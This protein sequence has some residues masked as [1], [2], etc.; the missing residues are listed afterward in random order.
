MNRAR[1]STNYPLSL[2]SADS[3][4]W[5]HL[6]RPNNSLNYLNKQEEHFKTTLSNNNHNQQQLSLLQQF[7]P[8]IEQ[9]ERPHNRIQLRQTKSSEANQI[10]SDNNDHLFSIPIPR[11]S[12]HSLQLNEQNLPANQIENFQLKTQPE[13]SPSKASVSVKQSAVNS[14]TY[15]LKLTVSKTQPEDYGEYSCIASNSIGNSE[16]M[17]TVTSKSDC[18]S[19]IIFCTHN[20]SSRLTKSQLTYTPIHFKQSQEQIR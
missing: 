2:S 6:R 15:K 17:I 8:T 14:Y 5:L 20:K 19:I 13:S 9:Q 12:R 3:A 18:C 7:K 11:Q 4:A 10:T 1:W 16:S